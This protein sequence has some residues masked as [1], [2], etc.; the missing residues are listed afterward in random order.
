MNGSAQ[1]VERIPEASVKNRVGPRH[2]PR[3]CGEYAFIVC[4]LSEQIVRGRERD[5]QRVTWCGKKS[6]SGREAE[7]DSTI[8]IGSANHLPAV[9]NRSRAEHH[10]GLIAIFID[11]AQCQFAGE[12]CVSLEKLPMELGTFDGKLETQGALCR[13]AEDGWKRS[14]GREPNHNGETK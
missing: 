6:I 5:D 12:E 10:K 2:L 7:V 14:A 8:T 13:W 4:P 9:G 3:A 11:D 1:V